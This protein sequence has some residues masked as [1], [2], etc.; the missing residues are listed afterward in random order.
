MIMFLASLPKLLELFAFDLDSYREVFSR[1][2]STIGQSLGRSQVGLESRLRGMTFK[3]LCKGGRLYIGRNVVFVGR[4]R[5]SLDHEV[6]IYGFTYLNAEGPS[7]FLSIGCGTRIDQFCA[8]YGQGGLDIGAWCAI[9][10]GV[11]IYSQSN[12]YKHDQ[13]K[14]VLEQPVIYKKVTIGDDVW[15][16]ANAVVLPG[17]QI[18]NSAIIGA[19]A[20]VRQDVP[21]RAIVGGVPAKLIGW[22]KEQEAEVP[23]A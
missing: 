9:A 12:Q 22:R 14:R 8:L 6:S 13:T 1:G 7:G 4:D 21:S 20:V 18:G 17:V 11:K 2:L 10:S 19:G 23:T 15:I 3:R 16:G 5:I